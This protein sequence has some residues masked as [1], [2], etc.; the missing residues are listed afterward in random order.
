MGALG[1]ELV[2]GFQLDLR[3][4]LERARRQARGER[5]AQPR[6]RYAGRV[7]GHGGAGGRLQHARHGTDTGNRRGLCAAGRGAHRRAPAA[8]LSMAAAGPRGRHGSAS[9]HREPAHRSRLVGLRASPCGDR[10]QLGLRGVECG[11]PAVGDCGAVHAAAVL[12]G[13]ARVHAPA[14]RVAVDG[15]SARD[16][17]H[18]R[19][20]S[21]AVCAGRSGDFAVD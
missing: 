15:G 17:L 14:Q 13:A 6:L 10:I 20:L 18:D 3:D 12:V 8:L 1:E 21:Y 9:A 4:L 5:A 7:R 16:A 19:V 11:L 2:P